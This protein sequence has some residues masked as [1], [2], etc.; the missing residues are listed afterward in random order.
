MLVTRYSY[1]RL[2]AVGLVVLRLAFWS[3]AAEAG[4]DEEYID[5]IPAERVKRLADSG[6]KIFFVDLR[7][8]NEFQKIRLPGARSIPIGELQ[9]RFAEIPK[10]GRVIL[11]CACP[12]GGVDEAYGYLTLRDKG[13][14]NVSVLEE[15]IAGWVK[16]KYPVDTGPN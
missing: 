4:H 13:H 10:S 12:S 9:K 2:F 3:S 5:T 6:E 16:R 1:I 11:Y 7:S 14:R 8:L 15:G